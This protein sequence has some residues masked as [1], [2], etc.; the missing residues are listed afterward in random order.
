MPQ[1]FS[2]LIVAT[3]YRAILIVITIIGA[4]VYFTGSERRLVQDTGRTTDNGLRAS[5]EQ[6]ESDQNK[7]L[8][9][10]PG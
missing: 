5:H 6:G 10:N 8:N 2:G 3:M 7:Q 9:H 1:E 4:I